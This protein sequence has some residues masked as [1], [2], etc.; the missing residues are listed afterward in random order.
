MTKARVLRQ[1]NDFAKDKLDVLGNQI[2]VTD[3]LQEDQGPKKEPQLTLFKADNKKKIF[4]YRKN[5]SFV[6][7]L[8]Y[9]GDVQCEV[10]A[11]RERILD[12]AGKYIVPHYFWS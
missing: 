10:E 11:D 4:I 5:G 6:V 7:R 3:L 9:R 2:L 12:E 8:W 1:F